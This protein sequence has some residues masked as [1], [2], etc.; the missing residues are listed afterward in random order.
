M[1]NLV[2][3]ARSSIGTKVVMAVTG[4]FLLGFV[5]VHML[6]NLQIFLGEDA[7]NAYAVALKRVPAVLWGARAALLL[8]LVSHVGAALKLAKQNAE[9]RPV[10]YAF[11]NTIQASPA[12]RSMLLSGF[13]VLLYVFALHIPHFTLHLFDG[14]KFEHLV[15]H[16]GRHNVYE[17][18]IRGFSNPL[19]SALYILAMLGLG[20]HLSHGISSVVQ[21]FGINHPRYNCAIK[22]AGPGIATLIVIGY[23]V[24]PMA[25]LLRILPLPAAT[26]GM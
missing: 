3:L 17:M 5:V 20:L 19:M 14:G 7:L 18:V 22:M 10:S 26:G 15:D 6:G 13:A 2:E 16:A 1:K 9:A 24:V 23:I 11:E 25:V 4:I 8:A 12:S 21:T